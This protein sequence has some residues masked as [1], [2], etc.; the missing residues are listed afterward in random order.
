MAAAWRE[1]R[2]KS[3]F[4]SIATESL[5]LYGTGSISWI[6]DERF[7]PRRLETSMGSI[8]HSVEMPRTDTV[9][10]L[11]L[12]LMLIKFRGAG[13]PACRLFFAHIQPRFPSAPNR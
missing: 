9:D 12:Q 11:G 10:P 7:P 4:A 3:I 8:S 5:V 6:S 1:A 13:R 2:K